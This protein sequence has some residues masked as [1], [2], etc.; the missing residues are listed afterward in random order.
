MPEKKGNFLTHAQFKLNSNG[1]KSKEHTPKI[2]IEKLNK[3][4]GQE[5]ILEFTFGVYQANMRVNV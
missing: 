1:G 4:K 5:F 2:G 3:T